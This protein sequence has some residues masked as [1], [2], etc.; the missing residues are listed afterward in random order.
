MIAKIGGSAALSAVNPP[1]AVILSVFD[2]FD[3]S[4]E[5]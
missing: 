2:W 4:A 5:A 3:L 1:F